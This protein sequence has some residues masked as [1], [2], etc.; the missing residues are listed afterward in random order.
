MSI[1]LAL[2]WS[3][4]P[5]SWAVLCSG[6]GAGV[7]HAWRAAQNWLS[8][9]PGELSLG[10]SRRSLLQLPSDG[11]RLVCHGFDC[12]SVLSQSSRRNFGVVWQLG[13]RWFVAK[14]Q[15]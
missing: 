5:A 11:H 13:S 14:G 1:V 9:A 12:F 3:C 6:K 7:S 10:A 4:P 8:R 15:L 2:I